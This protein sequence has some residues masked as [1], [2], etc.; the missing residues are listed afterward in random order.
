MGFLETVDETPTRGHALGVL[1]SI[2][3]FSRV[4][5]RL[6]GCAGPKTPGGHDVLLVLV[7][8]IYTPGTIREYL[9]NWQ[10][11]T[12]TPPG[13]RHTRLPAHPPGNRGHYPTRAPGIRR[14]FQE[15]AANEQGSREILRWVSWRL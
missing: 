14:V 5:Y 9:G 4:K 8:G 10:K 1:N 11:G 12:S 3:G 7:A 2:L 6:P 13:T 15:P